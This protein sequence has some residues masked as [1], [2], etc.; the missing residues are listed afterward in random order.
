M[1]KARRFY[2]EYEICSRKLVD[3]CFLC[4]ENGKQYCS[5][6][7]AARDIQESTPKEVRVQ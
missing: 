4:E 2:C 1:A 7:C 6:I 3:F 5:E